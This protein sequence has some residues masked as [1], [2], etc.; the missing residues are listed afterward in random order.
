MDQVE[1]AKSEMGGMESFFTKIPGIA[2]YREKEMRRDADKQLRD[3][4][5]KQLESRRRKLSGLENDL[6]DSGGIQ[7]MDDM[8]RVV[9]RLQLL[10]DRVKTASYGYAP[11][12]A[13][14]R[15]REDDLDRLIQFDQSLADE[16]SKLDEAIDG[17]EQAVQAN[18]S[19]KEALKTVGDVLTGLNETFGRRA[20]VIKNATE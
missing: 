17:L 7:W 15:V 1:K 18:G 6:L 20:D 2:G 11:L 9:G 10:I 12:F 4:L 14:N 19:V 16:V 8:E 5:A 3:A 13:L